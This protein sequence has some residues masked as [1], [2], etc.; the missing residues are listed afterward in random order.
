M[1]IS[2]AWTTAAFLAG[3]KTC[4]RRNWS[5]EYA[6]KFKVG[7]IHQAYDKNP[8]I[9]GHKIGELRILR[10]P[11]PEPVLYA[12]ES[13][14]EHEGLAWMDVHGLLIQGMT[15]W[16]FWRQWKEENPTVYVIRFTPLIKSEAGK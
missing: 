2:F 9:G 10:D 8:R 5:P 14:Y 6:A 1:I 3:E 11:Y 16:N 12:P 7:S 13:D 15:G 4:T